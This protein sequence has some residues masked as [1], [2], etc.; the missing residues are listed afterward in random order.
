MVARIGGDRGRIS[1][2]VEQGVS[3]AVLKVDGREQRG[4]NVADQFQ[5]ILVF[6]ARVVR[7]ERHTQI[8]PHDGFYHLFGQR[9]HGPGIRPVLLVDIGFVRQV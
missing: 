3:I 4:L 6:A 9:L 1:L 8:S 7:A 2:D 5:A